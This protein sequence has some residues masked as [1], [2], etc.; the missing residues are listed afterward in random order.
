MSK[1]NKN[2]DPNFKKKAGAGAQE[3]EESPETNPRTA[4]DQAPKAKTEEASKP[5]EKNASSQ[6]NGGQKETGKAEK[7]QKTEAELLQEKVDS[8]ND[9]LLRTVAE[10]DNFRKRSQREKDAIYPQATAKAVE[11]FLPI[12]DTIERALSV[13]CSDAEFKKG[14]EMILQNFKD[15]LEKLG[16]EEFGEAGEQFDP[17]IHNAVMHVEDE[18]H[19]ANTIAT[20][21][22]KG[23]RMD[24]K[25]IRHAMVQVAN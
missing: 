10:Y 11:K 5:E 6:E 22:Q 14:V 12:I 2:E 18:E 25:I 16:V 1:E 17:E 21:F 3:T 13:N 20:V 23:Y 7:P 15:V 9:K 24:D 19:E 8:L 4:E